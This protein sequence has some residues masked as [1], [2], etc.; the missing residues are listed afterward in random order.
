MKM[1]E[2]LFTAERKQILVVFH[3][4]SLVNFGLFNKSEMCE[5]LRCIFCLLTSQ[6]VLIIGFAL[7]F[8]IDRNNK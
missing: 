1:I 5:H 6:H 2:I 8:I 4:N 3:T 7:I